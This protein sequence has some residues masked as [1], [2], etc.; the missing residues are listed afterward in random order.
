MGN[1]R[2]LIQI[3]SPK[4]RFIGQRRQDTESTMEGD[5]TEIKRRKGIYLLPNLFT[6][7]C[8]FA[9]F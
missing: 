1:D 3:P 7:A 5:T 2:K 8:L 4:K 6:T 9:G